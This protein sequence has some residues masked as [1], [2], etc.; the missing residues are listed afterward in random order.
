MQADT[1][2]KR[3]LMELGMGTDIRGADYTKAAVRALHNAIRH[4]TISVAQAFGQKRE[5]MYVEVVIGVQK[6]D[7]VDTSMVA[8]VLPYGRSEVRVEQGG[9][10]TPSDDG[11]G[12]TVMANAVAIVYLDL[13]NAEAAS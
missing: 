9:L 7:Q 10:D 3:M 13:P 1:T 8:E 12:L 5:Q 11:E 6:P 2:R 4:N